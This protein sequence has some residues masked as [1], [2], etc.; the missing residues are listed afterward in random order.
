MV[1]GRILQVVVVVVVV[2]AVAVAVAVVAAAA[3]AA[4]WLRADV[5]GIDYCKVSK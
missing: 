4:L 2:V 5:S 3:A 1:F